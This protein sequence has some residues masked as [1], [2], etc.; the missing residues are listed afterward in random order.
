LRS[1]HGGGRGQAIQ[2]GRGGKGTPTVGV[3]P[4]ATPL[5]TTEA[6]MAARIE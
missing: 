2:R 6:I 5:P 4:V 1:S 3:P